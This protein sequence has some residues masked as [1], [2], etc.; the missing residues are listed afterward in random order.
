MK[1][2]KAGTSVKYPGIKQCGFISVEIVT[3]SHVVH[4]TYIVYRAGLWWQQPRFI[5]RLYQVSVYNLFPFAFFFLNWHI[6]D[7]PCC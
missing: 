5:S 6:V 1:E 3:R 7:L 2:R 4:C